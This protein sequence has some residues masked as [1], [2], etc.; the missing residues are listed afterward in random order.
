VSYIEQAVHS[1]V[2]ARILIGIEPNVDALNSAPPDGRTIGAKH[3]TEVAVG[4]FPNKD[5]PTSSTSEVVIVRQFLLAIVAVAAMVDVLPA[6][7]AWTIAPPG[8]EK[9]KEIKDINI[10]DR[11]N[12]LLHFYGDAVRLANRR[13]NAK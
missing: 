9:S 3:C 1:A 5:Y 12:R 8:T 6:S 7:A 4:L 2:M 11:P 13:S 10:L